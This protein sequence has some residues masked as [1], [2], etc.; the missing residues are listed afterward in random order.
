MT[1]APSS[2]RRQLARW[3]AHLGDGPFVMATLAVV[4]LAGWAGG[5]A[6]LCRMVGLSLLVVVAVAAVVTAIKFSVRRQRPRPPGEFVTLAYDAY[7]FPSGHSARLAALAVSVG[8][9]FPGLAWLLILVALLVA[10]AR[11]AVGIHYVG[12]IVV[13]LGLG[14]V[15]AWE[16][17]Y[18]VLLLAG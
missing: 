10:L 3:V 1:L 2:S 8:F 6:S 9:F 12:D 16:V 13:G 17:L 11:V 15:V 14:I 7:S 4:Y 18:L 5:D